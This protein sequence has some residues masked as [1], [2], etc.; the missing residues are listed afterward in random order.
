MSD[1]LT[2]DKPTTCDRCGAA[3][4]WARTPNDAKMPLDAKP[5]KAFQLE[6]VNA[7]GEQT[8]SRMLTVYESHFA[9]CPHADAFRRKR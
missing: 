2:T 3:L 7:A 9:T 6:P 5:R 8:V 1:G 4:I